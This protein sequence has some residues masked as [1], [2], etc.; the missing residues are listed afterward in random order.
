MSNKVV[1]IGNDK[2]GIQV[3]ELIKS[4][5]IEIVHLF[6]PS[7]STYLKKVCLEHSIP[8]T[9]TDNVNSN[10]DIISNLSFDLYL[11][12]GHPYLLRADLLDIKDGIG[13]HPSLLP[14]RRGRAPI[15]WAIIDGLT[16]S[17]VTIFKL[18]NGADNGDIFFQDSFSIN[19][20]DTSLDLIKKI[21]L[22][23]SKNLAPLIENWPN[24]KSTKQD[25]SQATYTHRRYPRD[26]EVNLNM[27][28]SEIDKLVRAL[29]GPYPSAFIKLSN[30]EK[31]FLEKVSKKDKTD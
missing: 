17:G 11:V 12:L 1:Y 24:L 4:K 27:S 5:K 25:E 28:A 23:L 14:K 31:I 8:F 10:I 13:F 21:N 20:D 19:S 30:G 9:E 22:I 7:K 6:M 18:D 3:P 26:G 15:N 2:W 16:K 29:T